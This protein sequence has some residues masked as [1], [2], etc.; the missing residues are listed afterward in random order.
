MV[1]R[2][3]F[4][5]TVNIVLLEKDGSYIQYRSLS[6]SLLSGPPL[7]DCNSGVIGYRSFALP[8][9]AWTAVA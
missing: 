9:N 7:L 6:N 5:V 4:G 8:V 1:F 2:L 3:S